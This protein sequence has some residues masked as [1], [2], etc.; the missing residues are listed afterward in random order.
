[1]TTMSKTSR[2]YERH[3]R[4]WG[5]HAASGIEAYRMGGQQ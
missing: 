1:M 3:R 4:Y 5:K 2:V